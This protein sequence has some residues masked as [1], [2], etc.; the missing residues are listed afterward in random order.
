MTATS[1]AG[2]VASV[3]DNTTQSSRSVD[4]WT[5]F[6]VTVMTVHMHACMLTSEPSDTRTFH[7]TAPWLLHSGR[8]DPPYFTQDGRTHPRPE[9][10]ELLHDCRPDALGAARDQAAQTREAEP[11]GSY[12]RCGRIDISTNIGGHRC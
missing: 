10:G 4:S 1:I 11:G 9:T 5:P 3:M 7:S 12:C 8:T 6:S 2:L